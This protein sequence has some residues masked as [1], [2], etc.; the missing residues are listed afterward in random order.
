MMDHEYSMAG[1]DSIYANR[2]VTAYVIRYAWTFG[3][4]KFIS[5]LNIYINIICIYMYIYIYIRRNRQNT[6]L[7]MQRKRAE[8]NSSATFIS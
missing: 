2:N 6:S 3:V 4:K 5:V 8:F 1:K 7:T